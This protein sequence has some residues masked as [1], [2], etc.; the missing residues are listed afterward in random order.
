MKICVLSCFNDLLARDTGGAVRIYSIAKNLSGLGHDIHVLIPGEKKAKQIVDGIIIHRVNGLT[1]LVFLQSLSNLFGIMRPTMLYFFDLLFILRVYKVLHNLDFDLVQIEQPW[2]SGLI[3]PLIKVVL[4]KGLVVDSHDVFQAL[5]I[6]QKL[7][8]RRP[9]EVFFEKLAYQLSDL[10]LVVS[11]NEKENLGKYGVR[12]SKIVVIPNGVDTQ[13]FVPVS[14]TM[15]N[16]NVNVP[17]KQYKVIFVGNMQYT[18]N[19][20]AVKEIALNLEPKVR[21]QI[22]N[23]RFVIVGRTPPNFAG[24]FSNVMFTGM[25]S[26]VSEWLT[27]SDVAIAPIFHGSGTRLKI[28]EYFSCGLPVVST[29]MGVEGLDIEDGVNIVIENDMKDFANKI[30]EL[31]RNRELSFK[32][33]RAAT[34]L[35]I[36]KYDWRKIVSRL[37]KIY[38]SSF[39]GEQ[40]SSVTKIGRK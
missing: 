7:S 16:H 8:L 24:S 4:K 21:R 2:T 10:I 35:V 18:P 9:L 5:R 36:E 33:G 12:K 39:S 31:L 6:G 13:T 34:Q 37:D 38:S 11:K 25:V 15:P 40:G 23:V 30:T 1:P 28:L 20:E 32:L 14:N 22:G 29:S 3:M 26:D 27:S 19:Q 17:T